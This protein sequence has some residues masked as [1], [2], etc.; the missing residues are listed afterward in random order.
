MKVFEKYLSLILIVNVSLGKSEESYIDCPYG[1]TRLEPL[2]QCPG[3]RMRINPSNGQY[4][5]L[6]FDAESNAFWDCEE[7]GAVWKLTKEGQL[8]NKY[9]LKSLISDYY[10]HYDENN[11]NL[12]PSVNGASF[13]FK[14]DGTIMVDTD[15][16]DCYVGAEILGVNYN[17]NVNCNNVNKQII[18][19]IWD[20]IKTPRAGEEYTLPDG[21][22]SLLLHENIIYMHPTHTLECKIESDDD[23]ALLDTSFIRITKDM[24]DAVD[25]SLGDFLLVTSNTFDSL[26]VDCNKFPA[27]K[28]T[29]IHKLIDSMQLFIQDAPFYEYIPEMDI[30]VSGYSVRDDGEEAP[31][32]ARLDFFDDDD[33]DDGI[34]G[35]S[36]FWCE[37]YDDNNILYYTNPVDGKCGDQTVIEQLNSVVP[38]GAV[39][40]DHDGLLDN[41]NDDDNAINIQHRRLLSVDSWVKKT[42]KKAVH[43]TTNFMYK[44]V[45]VP[46]KKKII[47]PIV[48]KVVKPIIK[49]VNNKVIKPVIKAAKDVIKILTG[50][51]D[52]RIFESGLDISQNIQ[53]EISGTT[54]TSD[55]KFEGTGHVEGNVNVDFAAKVYVDLTLKYKV[56]TSKPR[57]DE[58]KF[59]IGATSDFRSILNL[60]ITGEFKLHWPILEKSK[61]KVVFLGV[62]PVE[63]KFY[64]EVFTELAASKSLQMHIVVGYKP[65][66][67]K[68]GVQYR[69]TGWKKI[70]DTNL[71]FEP[72]R[73]ISTQINDVDSCFSASLIPAFGL[74]FGVV[75]YELVDVYLQAKL[76]IESQVEWPATC[77][78]T[79]ICQHRTPKLKISGDLHFTFAVGLEVHVGVFNIG[80]T[81]FGNE[82]DIYDKQWTIGE[83][84]MNLPGSRKLYMECAHCDDHNTLS[85]SITTAKPTT[86]TSTSTTTTSSTTTSTTTKPTTTT[87][88]TTTSTTTTS[89][90]AKPTTTTSSTTASSTTKRLIDMSTSNTADAII[91][92]G[93]YYD[94]GDYEHDDSLCFA[95]NDEDIEDFFDF[96]DM[97]MIYIS[98]NYSYDSSDEFIVRQNDKENAGP[99]SGA[100]SSSEN[101]VVL[102]DNFINSNL[103]FVFCIVVVVLS[104]IIIISFLYCCYRVHVQ[105]NKNKKKNI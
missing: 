59:V 47:K 30:D 89:T 22:G 35:V 94:Y 66:F 64:A 9:Q 48:K 41:E 71:K 81:K 68:F 65:I 19:Y 70:S 105:G 25:I 10:L 33:I 76:A 36:H 75:F 77:D 60:E 93:E 72:I 5:Y 104:A 88:T 27:V 53:L 67:L 83:N 44:K 73:S 37:E 96:E 24:Y 20:G 56:F 12:V 16:N 26:P 21:S 42:F 69:S 102:Y 11:N 14:D 80:F 100:A 86:A 91:T 82:W 43:K 98:C 87:S 45:V 13:I 3:F 1:D 58:F 101:V 54:G 79:S 38:F 95:A 31:I 15:T 2:Y 39:E 50:N 85:N 78:H 4:C 103:F 17:A 74:K 23:D 51:Y 62:I 34:I 28:V 92:T 8:D 63:M 18:E 7:N 32:K 99:S 57:F 49:T 61:R 55:G 6:S 29:Q 97:E 52:G 84:C 90:T 46:I 40:Y